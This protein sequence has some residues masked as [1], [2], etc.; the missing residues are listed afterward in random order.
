MYLKFSTFSYCTIYDSTGFNSNNGPIVSYPRGTSIYQLLCTIRILEYN[1]FSGLNCISNL[2]YSLSQKIRKRIWIYF[3]QVT[4]MFEIPF[5]QLYP[6][7]L[8]ILCHTE[9]CKLSKECFLKLSYRLF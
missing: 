1:L 5:A 4:I 8:N 2:Y 3:N 9:Y 6:E 7:G